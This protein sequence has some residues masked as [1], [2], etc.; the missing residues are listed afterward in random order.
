MHAVVSG[1]VRSSRQDP[2]GPTGVVA[3]DRMAA[4]R[5]A[6]DELCIQSSGLDCD[7]DPAEDGEPGDCTAVSGADGRWARFDGVER[8]GGFALC[9]AAARPVRRVDSQQHAADAER[10]GFLCCVVVEYWGMRL[11]FLSGASRLDGVSDFVDP[12]GP[13][14]EHLCAVVVRTGS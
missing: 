5:A 7:S 6:A 11:S 12:G 8:P 2:G 1:V 9:A 10:S 3:T 13:G 14:A 4:I